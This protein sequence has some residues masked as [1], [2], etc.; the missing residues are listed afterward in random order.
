MAN[1]KAIERIEELIST[2]ER[3]IAALRY[4]IEQ[5]ADEK[6]DER[7]DLEKGAAVHAMVVDGL[8]QANERDRVFTKKENLAPPP[9][10]TPGHVRKMT[11]TCSVCKAAVL[12]GHS[13]L[14][15]LER[16]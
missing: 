4:S 9:A 8:N 15:G 5:L 14:V 7:E 6:W 1:E 12:A 16:T 2:K 10:T 13:A 11:C 3:E